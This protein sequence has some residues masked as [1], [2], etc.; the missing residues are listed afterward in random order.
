MVIAGD[1]DFFQ[2]IESFFA[3]AWEI[4]AHARYDTSRNIA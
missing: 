1:K 3:A 4:D 2:K